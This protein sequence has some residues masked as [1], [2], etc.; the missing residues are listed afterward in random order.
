M[1]IQ[2]IFLSYTQAEVK[3]EIFMELLLKFGVEGGHA[4]EWVIL[5]DNNIYVPKYICLYWFENIKEG[6]E[7]RGFI[8]SQVYSCGWYSE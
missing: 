3:L 2:C 6:L 8:Q 5:M 1:P 7:Y 4:I